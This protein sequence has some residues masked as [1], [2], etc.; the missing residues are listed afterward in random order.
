MLYTK[1]EP[2]NISKGSK[3]E[4]SLSSSIT[5]LDNF[6]DKTYDNNAQYI[7]S[8]DLSNFDWSNVVSFGSSFKGCSS[9]KNV[10]FPKDKIPSPTKMESMFNG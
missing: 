2:I 8:I 5:S 4:I 6:F 10:I 1:D 3:I 7:E 9:L